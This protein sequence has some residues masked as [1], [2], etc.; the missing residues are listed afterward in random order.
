MPKLIDHD[1]RRVEIAEAAWRIVRREGVAAVSVRAVA[2]E[3]E[4]ATA[5]L[6][7]TFPT[8]SALLTFCFELVVERAATR[9][10]RIAQETSQISVRERAERV[11]LEVLP[12][13]P[14]RHAEMQV[15]LAFAAAALSNPQLAP[16]YAQGHD[17]L[18]ELC[19]AV[20][21]SVAPPADPMV[22]AARLHALVDGLGMHLVASATPGEVTVARQ[23][24]AIHLDS[25]SI[26][27]PG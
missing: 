10:G 19:R 8:Q 1:E 2:A 23:A 17:A 27:G 11:L 7:R 9:I 13:D 5:S 18:R 26:G 15:W 6:R 16:T 4:L 25:L 12:L 24:L 20:V 3:T 14:E 22:E 21:A